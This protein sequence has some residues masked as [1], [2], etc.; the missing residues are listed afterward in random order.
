M[1]RARGRLLI[2]CLAA[3]AA[4]FAVSG[5]SAGNRTADV[6]FKYLPGDSFTY[7][8]EFATETTITNSGSST[9]TQLTVHHEIPT[10]PPTVGSNRVPLEFKGSSCP[11]T[12]DIVGNEVVC[13]FDQLTSK[14]TLTVTFL[15][16]APPTGAGCSG[17][18]TTDGY[19]TIK[20]GKA[21]NANESFPF[22]DDT[23]PFLASL[24]GDDPSLERKKAGGYETAGVDCSAD[25]LHPVDNLHT[26]TTL[27][28]DDPVSSAVC[29]PPDGFTIPSGSSALGYSTTITEVAT[30]PSNGSHKEL[31]QSIVCVAALGQACQPT[32]C[33]SAQTAGCYTPVNWGT[34]KARQ[35]FRILQDAMKGPKEIAAVYHNGSKLPLCTE[36]NALSN[37]DGCVVDIIPPQAGASQEIWTVI[38]DAPT[39]GPWNW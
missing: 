17:C 21:T 22:V 39:N 12:D 14:A 23:G 9:F 15:W 20:E 32:A 6:T 31:G 36:P 4:A 13:T 25:P 35:I 1:K 26:N 27:S 2:V 29:L 19:W 3:V 37:P 38:A 8:Q 7:G 16:Q 34:L 5:G 10:I 30:K 28:K 11:G 33:V 24:L 18:V